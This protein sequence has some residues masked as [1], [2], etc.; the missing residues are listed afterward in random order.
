MEYCNNRNVLPTENNFMWAYALNREEDILIQPD[1][2][3]LS[4]YIENEAE[5]WKEFMKNSV[6]CCTTS[7]SWQHLKSYM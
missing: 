6:R 2:W 3:E 4:Q 7:D 1:G 5:E